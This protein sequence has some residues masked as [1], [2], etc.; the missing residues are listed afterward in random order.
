MYSDEPFFFF[1]IPIFPT[2][3]DNAPSQE[4]QQGPSRDV[5]GGSLGSLSTSTLTGGEGA[6][7]DAV[8]SQGNL[9]AADDT[10]DSLTTPL[11][12]LMGDLVQPTEVTVHKINASSAIVSKT[13]ETLTSPHDQLKSKVPFQTRS[14]LTPHFELFNTQPHLS[15][16]PLPQDAQIHKLLKEKQRILASI[17]RLPTSSE[18]A[19]M[20]EVAATSVSEDGHRQPKNSGDMLLAA[21]HQ[22]TVT[23][24]L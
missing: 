19:D 2:V 14:I 7:G 1:H 18:F 16:S 23:V 12:P 3:S 9:G 6:G 11:T 20:A 24:S 4:D 17:H 5:N 13:G 22:G 21:W 10:L 15:P 8:S